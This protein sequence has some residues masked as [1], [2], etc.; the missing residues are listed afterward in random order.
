MERESE[1]ERLE[2]ERLRAAKL[3]S[4]GTLAGGIAHDFNNLLTG[5]MG[6][7]G[8]VK[9]SISPS[10]AA[11]EMLD[12]AEKAALRARDLTQQLL[13]FARGGKPVKKSVEIAEILKES[14][15]F[16]LR[17]SNVKLELSIPDDLWPIEADEG[18]INQVINN[19]IINAD[20]AMPSGGTLKIQAENLT[21]KKMAIPLLPGGNYVHIDIADTGMGISPEHLERIFEPYF[22]TKQRGSG[23]G[24]TTA[25][26]IVRNHGGIIL[27]DS[28]Q[29]KGSTFQIYL[30]ATKKTMKGDKKMKTV[31]SGQAD[32]KVLVMDDDEIIR[33]MLKN[34][35][36]M[37][38]YTVELS[39]DGAEAL[40]K[41]KHAIK[42]GDPFNAVIMD[43]T[44]PGGM[45]GREAVKKLLEID[46]DATV[47]VSSG[48]ATDPIMSEYKKY[49]F[50]AVIAKPY[51]V[52][53]LQE[54]LSSIL[55]KG[56]K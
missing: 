43:L 26:S 29:N 2:Q 50:K 32:G 49:G 22:T 5:I 25:Y 35:L 20:E 21:L 39:A 24:L 6:N 28:R 31:S 46:P 44:I 7:I 53:Q 8:L 52:K 30:P 14:A 40:E 47:I 34:M 11:Y 18:Q 4:I 48:Y 37:A 54:S 55:T 42:T 41:Y 16:A 19:L 10:D 51:S 3:E 45:G 1:Y 33:K 17:G 38:G 27:A 15:A 36:S 9:T 12:E 13:T 56:K 23:L